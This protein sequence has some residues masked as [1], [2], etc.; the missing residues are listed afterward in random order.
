LTGWKKPK[1]VREITEWNPI[2]MRSKVRPKNT[3]R[4]EVINDL[5]KL[6]MKN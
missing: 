1:R 5:N 3:W 6:K 2:R 4:V